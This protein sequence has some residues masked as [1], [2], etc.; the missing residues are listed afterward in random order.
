MV[1]ETPTVFQAWNQVMQAIQSIG[2]DSLN[3]DQGFRFRGID[4]VVDKV[5]PLL[6]EHGVIVVPGAVDHESERYVTK[7]GSSMMGE[8]VKMSY[9]V[10]GPA[11]DSFTGAAFG[12]A[13]DSGDK[14]MAKAE[15]VALRVFLLEALMIPTG[16]PDPDESSHERAE[17]QQLTEFDIAR[18]Q[19]WSVCNELNL[20]R[21][22]AEKRC[23]NELG[24]PVTAEKIHEFIETL[25]GE[26]KIDAEVAS[27]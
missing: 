17:Q 4:A 20:D 2:K 8:T 25:R 16:D 26:A 21:S 9:T 5:G 18:R 19:L 10:Y 1:A 6:R 13:A 22:E 12:S 15:S 7:K 27:S 11:G 14:A 24:A 3:K 23:L